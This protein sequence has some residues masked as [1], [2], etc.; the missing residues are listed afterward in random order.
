MAKE[1]HVTA[2]HRSGGSVLVLVLLVAYGITVIRNA[3]LSE[4]AYITYRTVDNFV[5]GYGLTWN[6]AERVQV[7]T[8]PLWMLLHA[9]SYAFTH[10]IYFTSLALSIVASL[11]TVSLGA[12]RLS[13]SS[14]S[15][16]VG[17]VILLFS[18]AFVDYSTSGLE[19]PLTHLILVVFLLAYFRPGPADGRRLSLLSLTAALGALTRMDSLLLFL[20]PLLESLWRSRSR[21]AFLFVALGFAPLALWE[22]FSLLYYGFPFPN[23]AYAKLN[24]GIPASELLAQGIAYLKDSLVQDRVTLPA[25]VGAVTAAAVVCRRELLPLAIG[26]LLYLGYVVKIGGDFMSGRFLAAPLLCAVAIVWRIQFSLWSTW[27][28]LGLILGAGV[29]SPNPPPFCGKDYGVDAAIER[30]KHEPDDLFERSHGIADERGFY[31]PATGLLRAF[32]ARES[33]SPW[34]DH[35]W[36]TAGRALRGKGRAIHIN[37][38]IGL[39]GFFAGPEVHFIDPPALTDALLS[40]LPV[41]KHWRIGHF[42]RVIPNGYVETILTGRNQICD[43]KLARYYDKLA[44]ATRGRLFSRSRLVAIWELNTHQLDHLIDRALYR[45]LPSTHNDKGLTEYTVEE[46]SALLHEDPGDVYAHYK[47]GIAYATRG[48]LDRALIHWEAAQRADPDDR[49]VRRDLARAYSIK[50]SLSSKSA[51]P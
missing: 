36:A 23:T 21:R 47:A 28:A 34:P 6:V 44:L 7:Y 26:I 32:E 25:I 8:H 13:T 12:L 48:D 38:S 24:T 19:N 3:W 35:D 41:A 29:L 1:R 27:L 43:E 17:V 22:M 20:P 37:S 9:A 15:A 40:R 33:G 4:D 18:K 42:F 10:E 50:R 51:T 46:L 49:C 30:K 5:H 14:A 11:C 39:L 31:Y 2:E 45:R 16:V